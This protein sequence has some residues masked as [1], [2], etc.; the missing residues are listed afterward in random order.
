MLTTCFSK[1]KRSIS[2]NKFIES[3]QSR[4]SI[5]NF[6][7][8]HIFLMIIIIIKFKKLKHSRKQNLLY[9]RK[10]NEIKKT[11][12]NSQSY[13]QRLCKILSNIKLETKLI[14]N[15][16]K[17]KKIYR[18]VNSRFQ[19]FYRYQNWRVQIQS[20][21]SSYWNYFFTIFFS[22]SIYQIKYHTKKIK[23][24]KIH[25][26][27]KSWRSKTSTYSKFKNFLK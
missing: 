20:I 9:R 7:R 17:K 6:D 14:V 21:S 2:F 3:S 27:Y 11:T 18:V 4:L 15:S 5:L 1:K 16:K 23:K 22:I 12:I 26:T 13:K 19:I 24:R 25:R 10:L 8:K